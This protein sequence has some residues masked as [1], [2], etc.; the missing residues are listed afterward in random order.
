MKL[1]KGHH[2]SAR[3]PWE[4]SQHGDEA[5]GKI[6]EMGLGIFWC[7]KR[8]S[9]VCIWDLHLPRLSPRTSNKWLT[10]I[11]REGITH[12]PYF[13]HLLCVKYFTYRWDIRLLFTF[14]RYQSRTYLRCR[15]KADS[16]MVRTSAFACRACNSSYFYFT[17]WLVILIPGGA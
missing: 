13:T 12:E 5:Y 3:T 8:L 9:L 7:W 14:V 1:L 15:L 17:C 10:D 4:G 2:K 6:D 16:V 11:S